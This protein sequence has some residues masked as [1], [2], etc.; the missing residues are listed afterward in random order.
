MKFRIAVLTLLFAVCAFGP[1]VNA[2]LG[3]E[4]M[5]MT[6]TEFDAYIRKEIAMNLAIVKAAN[7]KF[8]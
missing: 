5:P 4:P 7:L 6:P 8:D 3:N 1:Q 2:L